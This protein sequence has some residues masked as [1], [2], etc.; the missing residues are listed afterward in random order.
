MRLRATKALWEAGRK[1]LLDPVPLLDCSERLRLTAVLMMRKHGSPEAAEAL[2]R[3]LLDKNLSETVR[4]TAIDAIGAVALSAPGAVGCRVVG[5][6]SK[7]TPVWPCAKQATQVL[8]HVLAQ[9]L[10]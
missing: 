6:W 4:L 1:D 9:Q 3:A 7:A 5:S 2:G 8:S 10:E